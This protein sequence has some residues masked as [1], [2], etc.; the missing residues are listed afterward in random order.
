[1]EETTFCE[2]YTI[3]TVVHTFLVSRREIT[4]V[5]FCMFIVAERISDTSEESLKEY[6]IRRILQ[7]AP[8]RMRR[9]YIDSSLSR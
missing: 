1:M 7:I 3:T 9:Q 8:D 5:A 2:L 6:L 4:A